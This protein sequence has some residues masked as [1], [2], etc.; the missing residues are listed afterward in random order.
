MV[1]VDP[2]WTCVTLKV[3]N[4]SGYY[5]YKFLANIWI[6]D[7]EKSLQP[8]EIQYNDQIVTIIYFYGIFMRQISNIFINITYSVRQCHTFKR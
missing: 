6:Y 5:L 7:S 2:T 1:F 3:L 8:F 4:R